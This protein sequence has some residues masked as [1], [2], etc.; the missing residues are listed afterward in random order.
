MLCFEKSKSLLTVSSVHRLPR[1]KPTG[2]EIIEYTDKGG[3][4]VT[5]QKL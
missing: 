5:G 1:V 4:T 3:I 2:A